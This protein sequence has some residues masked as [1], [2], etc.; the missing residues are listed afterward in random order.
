[1]HV[2]RLSCDRAARDAIEGNCK[3]DIISSWLLFRRR[4]YRMWFRAGTGVDADDHC[5]HVG[6]PEGIA[7]SA[8]GCGVNVILDSF[9]KCSRQNA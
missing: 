9:N 5:G 1:V 6:L 3:K 7:R 2:M 8:R 4:D